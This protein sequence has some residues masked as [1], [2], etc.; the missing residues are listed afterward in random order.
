M[1]I[2]SVFYVNFLKIHFKCIVSSFLLYY[3]KMNFWYIKNELSV[4][5]KKNM[6]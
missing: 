2:F 4:Y 1:F 5:I 3:L 6:Y